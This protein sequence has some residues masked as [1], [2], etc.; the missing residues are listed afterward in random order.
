MK[1]YTSLQALG[2]VK[3]TPTLDMSDPALYRTA[4]FLS[5]QLYSKY[6]GVQIYV[7]STQGKTALICKLAKRYRSVCLYPLRGLCL[8]Q[9]CRSIFARSV[10]ILSAQAGYCSVTVDGKSHS[11]NLCTVMCITK[12]PKIPMAND[13]Y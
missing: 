6:A 7:R 10:H 13:L 4:H 8:S 9:S 11:A 12:L 1:C 5:M 2:S 3:N